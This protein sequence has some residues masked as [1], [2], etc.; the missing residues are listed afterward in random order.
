M[1]SAC[2]CCSA[3]KAA[4]VKASDGIYK[5]YGGTVAG[6]QEMIDKALSLAEGS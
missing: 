6:A 4:F 2:N 3:D 1:R 5:E